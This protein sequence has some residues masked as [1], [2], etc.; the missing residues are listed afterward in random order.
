MIA[1][2]TF[3]NTAEDVAGNFNPS[4]NG[5]VD[6]TYAA[7]RNAA[8]GMAATFNGTTSIIEIPNGDQLINT[9]DF[10]IS[11]WVKT[12]SEGITRG[13]FV[14]GLGAHYGIQFEIFGG[15]DGAKFAIS[16]G[17]QNGST[18]SEDMWFPSEATDAST[19]GWQG[20]DYARSL[21]QAQMIAMLKDTWL[22]V[23]YT[24]NGSTKKGTLYYNGERMKSFDFNLWPEEDAKRTVT[25]L[26]YGGTAPDVVNELAFGFIHSR[27][28]TMWDNE[29]WGGYDFPDANHFKGQ[30]DD[31]KIYHKVLTPTEIQLMYASEN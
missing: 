4:A 8:A 27:A 17:L 18:A 31:V 26:K 2:W 25:G 23:T 9:S 10:T 16:Y 1:N 29:P 11:F 30:L 20:W 19:G 5:V 22:Q 3:E 24:Y 13:H 21:T 14:M 7:S 6:I 15:Y 12:N 28:G